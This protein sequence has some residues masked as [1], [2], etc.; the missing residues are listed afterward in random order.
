MKTTLHQEL[1]ALGATQRLEELNKERERLIKLIDKYSAKP[2]PRLVKSNKRKKLHWTQLPGGRERMS[3]IQRARFRN[4][5]K[6][7]S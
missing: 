1:I 5:K 2:I 4:A 7:H 6:G 3:R